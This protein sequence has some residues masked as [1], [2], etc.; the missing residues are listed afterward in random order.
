MKHYSCLACY[1]LLVMPAGG[2]WCCGGREQGNRLQAPAYAG[3]AG[4]ASAASADA[5]ASGA[6]ESGVGGTS[7]LQVP[8]L[9]CGATQCS[10]QTTCCAD[11]TE[12]GYLA[13]PTVFGASC[14]GGGFRDGE[15]STACPASEP[16][17]HGDVCQTFT[18]CLNADGDCGY[19]VM[20]YSVWDAEMRID[21]SAELGCVIPGESANQ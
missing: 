10:G 13:A 3:T 1:L 12:C 15:P 4:E 14:I 17:C 2:L 9:T 5:G 7:G 11:A 20:A 19:W 18:G 21:I 8:T 16:Y 6:Q